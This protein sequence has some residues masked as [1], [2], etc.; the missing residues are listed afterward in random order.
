MNEQDPNAAARRAALDQMAR[1]AYEAGLYDSKVDA[2]AMVQE[3]RAAVEHKP[4]CDPA[5][6]ECAIREEQESNPCDCGECS[7]CRMAMLKRKRKS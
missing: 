6:A 7:P 4:C 3:L 5:C 2:A 1:D